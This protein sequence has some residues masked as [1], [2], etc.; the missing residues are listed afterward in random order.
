MSGKVIEIKTKQGNAAE[1]L[2]D[3]STRAEHFKGVLLVG[4]NKEDNGLFLMTSQLT[5]MQKSYLASF[6]QAYHMDFMKVE[7][8]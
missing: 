3:F 7:D 5:N 6:V 2:A 4:L 8:A 1:T